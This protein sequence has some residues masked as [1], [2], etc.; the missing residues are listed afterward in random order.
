MSPAVRLT[1]P[2]AMKTTKYVSGTEIV[3]GQ[4]AW[5][6]FASSACGDLA[7]AQTLIAKDPRL[8]NAQF[9]YRFPLHLAVFGDHE[10][11]VA[12]LLDNGADPGQ[13]TYTY[14]S[15]DKLLLAARERGQES[16]ERLL[17][18]KMQQ[19]LAY[20]PEFAALQEAIIARDE[21]QV[22]VVLQGQPE[23]LGQSDALGNGA[24]HWSVITRQLELIPKFVRLGAPID[25]R[26]ADGH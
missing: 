20:L 3:N 14:D 16:I 10:P 11:I 17:R 21:R 24:L 25:A 5:K 26:R 22:D 19:L 2:P 12:L 7:A 8:V 1:Q 4:D 15:W 13:S 9:W 23:L 18:R 6:L